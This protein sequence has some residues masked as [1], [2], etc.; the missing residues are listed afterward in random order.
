MCVPNKVANMYVK[1]K[2]SVSKA[3]A[4]FSCLSIRH[5]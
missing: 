1:V 3:T 2:A 4:T 5:S